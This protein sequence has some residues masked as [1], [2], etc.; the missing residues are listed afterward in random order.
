VGAEAPVG[1]IDA[2]SR[3]ETE[4]VELRSAVVA[5]SLC[6]FVVVC[7]GLELARGTVKL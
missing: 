7:I 1:L 5:L 4:L 3:H 2:G 6:L